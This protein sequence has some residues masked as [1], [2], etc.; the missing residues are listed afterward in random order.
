MLM[1]SSF[2]CAT[3]HE[4]S[5][6]TRLRSYSLLNKL[7]LSATTRDAALAKSA[8]TGVF[9]PVHIGAR[10]YEDGAL[11]AN[12]PAEEVEE[13]YQ[14][15]VLRQPRFAAT[16]QMLRLCWHGKSWKEGY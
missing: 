8:A 14:H 15:L 4:T 9:D 6:I 13:S 5:G 1:K 3:A 12:N 10:K 11:G 7:N 2:V 16:C